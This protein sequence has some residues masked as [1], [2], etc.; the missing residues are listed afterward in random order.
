MPADLQV[1]CLLDG[2]VRFVWDDA[3]AELV[4]QGKPI[5][6][7]VSEVVPGQD[8][9]WW[10]VLGRIGGPSLGPFAKSADAIAAEVEWLRENL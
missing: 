7:R 3:L 8:G 4:A 2:S 9:R 6:R 10:S 5:I 1:D